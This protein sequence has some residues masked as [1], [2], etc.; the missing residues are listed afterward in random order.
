MRESRA[1]F[2][3][4]TRGSRER[5]V[6][7]RWVRPTH[8]GGPKGS[9]RREQM[10]RREISVGDVEEGQHHHGAHEDD[11]AN[12][13]VKLGVVRLCYSTVLTLNVGCCHRAHS[14][15]LALLNWLLVGSRVEFH[16]AWA[17]SVLRLRFAV[18]RSDATHTFTSMPSF[19]KRGRWATNAEKSHKTTM[20]CQLRVLSV[21][22]P[23][24]PRITG[25]RE[26]FM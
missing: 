7:G 24:V 1:R 11:G 4:A 26:P 20:Q 2:G 5:R 6:F 9:G 10:E 13:Q 19:S 18:K 15:E 23:S 22:E 8:R 25:L 21:I 14:Q 17:V 3:G 12:R 16:A